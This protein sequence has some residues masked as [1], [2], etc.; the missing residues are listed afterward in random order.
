LYVWVPIVTSLASLAIALWSVIIATSEPEVLMLMP[1]RVR[2]AHSL[3]NWTAAIVYVQPSFL[4]TAKNDRVEVISDIKLHV[5]PLDG[6]EGRDFTWLQHGTWE[7]DPDQ[8]DLQYQYAGDPGPLTV[9]P[10][11]AQQPIV[12]F[13]T[14]PGWAFNEGDYRLTVTATRVVSAASLQES[15]TISLTA[16]AVASINDQ[17]GNFWEVGVSP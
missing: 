13:I 17:R 8:G 9:S 10:S 3:E 12:V 4:S 14:D 16:D 7:L 15:F 5:Q 1:Q 2:V 6:G 11:N